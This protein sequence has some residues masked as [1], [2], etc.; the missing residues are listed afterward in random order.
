M[1]FLDFQYVFTVVEL[2]IIYSVTV[3]DHI[4]ANKNSPNWS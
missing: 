2:V 1:F 4:S 3:K